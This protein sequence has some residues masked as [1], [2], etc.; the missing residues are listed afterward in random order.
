MRPSVLPVVLAICASCQSAQP[1]PQRE[2]MTTPTHAPTG[3][4]SFGV[5]WRSVRKEGV[6]TILLAVA[7]PAGE[8]P[9]P[10][11]VIL[12]G[13]HGF[14]R[15]YVQMAMQ[16]SR[17]GVVAVAVC[18]FAPGSGPGTRF[19]SPLSCP[20]D[21]PPMSSHQSRQATSTINAAMRA[22]RTLPDVQGDQ[23]ALFGH[24]RGGGATW[25]YALQGGDAQAIILNSAGYPDE[26]I[27]RANEI[28][29]PVLI[30]HGERDGP[31]D[32]GSPMTDVGRARAFHGALRKAGKPV[33]AAF[34]QAGGHNGLFASPSQQADEVQRI[35]TFL[36]QHLS[37]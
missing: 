12:H 31:E 37:R 20:A 8:G 33:E 1:K 2:V 35:G 23:I 19:V 26:L 32:G 4:E 29:I 36:R 25:N 22:V 21:S 11:V 17:T 30:L 6:G 13:S 9:F 10:A 15:E 3:A 16:L 28:D 27:R 34:Y 7:R 24:S 5:E 18:W 14:A